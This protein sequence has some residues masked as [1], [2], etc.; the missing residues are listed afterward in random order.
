MPY[1]YHMHV[2]MYV[3]IA[4]SVIDGRPPKSKRIL[5]YHHTAVIIFPLW[6]SGE[7]SVVIG[8]SYKVEGGVL[9]ISH[10]HTHLQRQMHTEFG[11]I[12]VL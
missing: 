3:Y 7:T 6:A 10:T 9:F 4:C 11:R 8:N 2:Y 12:F 5:D 1:M